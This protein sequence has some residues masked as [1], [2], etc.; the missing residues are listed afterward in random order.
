MS[1]PLSPELLNAIEAGCDGVSP[2]PWETD[3]T[4]SDGSYG[5][6]EDTY[7]GFDA[8]QLI[9]PPLYPGGRDVVICDT[10]NSDASLINE[11]FGE[12][13][14]NAWDEQGRKN[15]AHIARL[16]P[17]TVREL[18]AGYRRGLAGEERE[19][20]A[21]AALAKVTEERD[22]LA[23]VRDGYLPDP[24]DATAPFMREAD[25]P[26][27]IKPLKWELGYSHGPLQRAESVF[28][29]YRVWMPSQAKTGWSRSLED[30]H[31]VKRF[32]KLKVSSDA[33]AIAAVEAEYEDKVRSLLEVP[34]V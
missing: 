15:M 16:D 17:A 11:E 23:R 4:R 27:K 9:G 18:V 19:R 5:F 20:E 12:E 26:V 2:G 21:R 8:Y 31:A 24:P 28:G 32:L 10:L 7:E 1:S 25:I 30:D 6:G 14:H 3:T 29:T 34:H 33:E 13:S 22:A